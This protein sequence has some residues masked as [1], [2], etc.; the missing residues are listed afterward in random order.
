MGLMQR[1]I[2]VLVLLLALVGCGAGASPEATEASLPAGDA[3][4]GAELFNTSVNGAPSCE[5][6]HTLTVE[7]LV[8]PGLLGYGEQAGTQVEGQT[9]EDYSYTSIVR[10]ADHVV[11]GFGNLMYTQYERMLSEQEIADLMAFILTQ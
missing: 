8:G 2:L 6:C 9:A 11:D 4:R 10:P 7:T 5:A 1:G 3:A